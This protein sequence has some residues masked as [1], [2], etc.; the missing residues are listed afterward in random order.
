MEYRDKTL[1]AELQGRVTALHKST[2]LRERAAAVP[3]SLADKLREQKRVEAEARLE[4]LRRAGMTARA[5]D[6][7]TT[8]PEHPPREGDHARGDDGR[9][10]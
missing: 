5:H 6:R 10:R 4:Q 1:G 9:E 3:R 8:D 7:T 2:A